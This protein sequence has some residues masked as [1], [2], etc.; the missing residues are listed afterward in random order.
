[1][2]KVEQWE[3]SGAD[4]LDNSR[5]EQKQFAEVHLRNNF[6]PRQMDFIR[7][8]PRHLS[9]HIFWFL[10]PRILCWCS[11]PDGQMPS[12]KTVGGGGGDV[13]TNTFCVPI[14]L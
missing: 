2:A 11:Q 14:F 8:L 3:K 10:D 13:L 12:D 5:N 9:F 4:L 1:M 6:P 7:V